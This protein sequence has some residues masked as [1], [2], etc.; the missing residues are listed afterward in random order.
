MPLDNSNT[1]SFRT[2]RLRCK[3]IAGG[4]AQ[5]VAMP[6]SNEQTAPA[7]TF[8]D[9]KLGRMPYLVQPNCGPVT[10]DAG[11]CIESSNI[12]ATCPQVSGS[13]MPTTLY[14]NTVRSLY[15]GLPTVPVGYVGLVIVLLAPAC[16]QQ[17]NISSLILPQPFGQTITYTPMSTPLYSD[18]TLIAD[19]LLAQDFIVIFDPT[20]T[21][22]NLVVSLDV[23]INGTIQP[24]NLQIVN[25]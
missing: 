10:I 9:F 25:V 11:C 23:T 24:C 1:Q 18:C 16:S 2:H 6:L 17:F 3:A 19:P 5:N 15:N 7:S 22:Q 20:V 4:R 13:L 12:C 21:Y 14:D 8:T